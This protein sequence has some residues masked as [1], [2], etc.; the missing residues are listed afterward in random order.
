MVNHAPNKDKLQMFILF[1]LVA[2]IFLLSSISLLSFNAFGANNV[3]TITRVRVTNTAPNLTNVFVT[4]ST[5]DLTPGNV[6][7]VNCTGNFYDANGWDDIGSIKAY[8]YDTDYGYGATQDY[9]FRYINSSCGNATTACTQLDATNSSC[10]CRFD[11]RYFANNGSWIC[12]MT[13]GDIFGLNATENSS[14]MAINPTIGINA[15]SEIDFG[16]LSITETSAQK[17]ANLSNYGNVPINV[18]LRGYGGTDPA[19]QNN[20]S[21]ICDTGNISNDYERYSTASGTAFGAMYNVTNETTRIS[22]FLLSA[23]TND[24]AYGNDT[25]TTYWRLYVPPMVSGYCNGTLEFYAEQN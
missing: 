17:A 7:N 24:T 12:N 20:I 2:G 8:L 9:N 25:N 22:G 11:V 1:L 13:I 6:T 15:P 10:T 16:N 23:R 5:I 21:M 3:T 18:T 19:L 4:P 14:I